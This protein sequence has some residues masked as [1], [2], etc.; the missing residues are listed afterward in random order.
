STVGIGWGSGWQHSEDAG[1]GGMLTCQC[2]FVLACLDFCLWPNQSLRHEHLA[3]GLRTLVQRD[4]SALSADRLV[5][6]TED[7]IRGWF[8]GFEIPNVAERA[9]NIRELG[10]V[11]RVQCGGQAAL[12]VARAQ[13]SAARL[14]E[15]L[16]CLLPNF[17]DQAVHK[18]RQCYFYSRGQ[19]LVA[20]L[21][22]AY[23]CPPPGS[24]SPYAFEDLE[25]MSTF[26]DHRVPQIL[27]Y[28]GIIDYS[29]LLAGKIANSVGLQAG[30]EEEVRLQL[31]RRRLCDTVWSRINSFGVPLSVVRI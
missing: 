4:P 6:T 15:F 8:L 11:L 26:A 17:R 31:G 16:T 12:L 23:G 13:H 22:A 27:S 2:I 3:Q 18:G 7:T 9:K 21:W 5:N 24:G 10:Y 30:A 29:N 14:V 25:D 20:E 28:L 1:G 19:T